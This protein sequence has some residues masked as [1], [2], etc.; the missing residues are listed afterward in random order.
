MAWSEFCRTA[1][2]ASLCALTLMLA[3]CGGGVE[4]LD[5]LAAADADSSG[6]DD[7]TGF[8]KIGKPYKV[9]GRW[10]TPKH[11]ENYDEVG[12]AS[13]YGPKFHGKSTANGE[14]FDQDALTAAHP[15]LPL[16]SYV[17]VTVVKTGKSAVLRVNDRGPFGK[18]RILDVSK[19]AATKLGFRNA[20]YAKVRVEYLGEAPVGGGD[21][22]TL[23]A[24]SKYGKTS[25]TSI[26]KYLPFGLGGSESDDDEKVEVRLASA[27]AKSQKERD[28]E[29]NPLRGRIGPD[30][31]TNLP[32]V[33]LKHNYQPAMLAAASQPS[34]VQAYRAEIEKESGPIDPLVAMNEPGPSLE[35]EEIVATG[36]SEPLPEE[37]VAASQSRV[38]GAF[39]MFGSGGSSASA[40]ASGT[41]SAKEGGST[42]QAAVPAE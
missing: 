6:D 30:E 12:R 8:K 32:G 10:Y 29:N 31:D 41:A 35:E 24:E 42:L 16:P 26:A 23:Q 9:G 15:T 40:P 1:A 20:G 5:V 25:K 11:D 37:T 14:A 2:M 18:G 28:E 21:K 38:M 17:R 4:S 39:D 22:E 3:G 36:P 27:K 33:K 13:W 34:A 19:A 7:V